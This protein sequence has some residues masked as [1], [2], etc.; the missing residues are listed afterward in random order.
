M[1]TG[2]LAFV[3]GMWLILALLLLFYDFLEI[4][5]VF[6]VLLVYFYITKKLITDFI[7]ENHKIYLKIQT[8]SHHHIMTIANTKYFKYSIS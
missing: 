5:Y 7:C 3:R 2:G 1:G 8:N 6:L 4:V